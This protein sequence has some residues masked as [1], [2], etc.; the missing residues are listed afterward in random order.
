MMAVSMPAS[1]HRPRASRRCIPH[2]GGATSRLQAATVGGR[3]GAIR[4]GTATDTQTSKSPYL[5]GYGRHNRRFRADAG[6]RRSQVAT[7]N[8]Q[9]PATTGRPSGRRAATTTPPHTP[10]V[11]PARVCVFTLRECGAGGGRIHK[12]QDGGAMP[13][14][15]RGL[16]P[17]RDRTTTTTIGTLE[18]YSSSKGR[19][20]STKVPQFGGASR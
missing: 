15:G 13:R 7:R 14:R 3:R 4:A 8:S 12:P 5:D 18:E 16:R 19:E 20:S 10:T 9:Q 2:A 1:R 17:R 6:S 11:P